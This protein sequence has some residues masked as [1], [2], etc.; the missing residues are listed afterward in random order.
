[1]GRLAQ[2][3]LA[4]VAGVVSIDRCPF[5]T[6]SRAPPTG[7]VQWGFSLVHESLH[8]CLAVSDPGGSRAAGHPGP[9]HTGA[10]T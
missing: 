7:P 2:H 8:A 1:M 6:F 9:S 3:Q 4:L 10:R 5:G